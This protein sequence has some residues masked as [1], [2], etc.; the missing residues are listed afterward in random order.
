MANP[1][2]HTPELGHDHPHQKGIQN[3][4][5][6]LHFLENMETVETPQI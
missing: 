3:Y 1:V 4:R 6:K 2:L 5:G